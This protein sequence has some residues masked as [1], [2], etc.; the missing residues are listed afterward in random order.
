MKGPNYSTEQLVWF[1]ESFPKVHGKLEAVFVTI[2]EGNGVSL[3]DIN[4]AANTSDFIGN[5]C[6]IALQLAGFIEVYEQGA[7]KLCRVTEEGRKLKEVIE[8]G[9][10]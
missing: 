8:K 4:K 3:S 1:Y 5:K 7:T 2:A 6:V 10:N 9:R